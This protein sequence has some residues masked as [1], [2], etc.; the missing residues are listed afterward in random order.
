MPLGSLPARHNVAGAKN[1]RLPAAVLGVGWRGG[2]WSRHHGGSG[3][4]R[5][6]G[7]S[8]YVAVAAVLV[9]GLL[10]VTVAMVV[11][12]LLAP[13]AP[14]VGKLTTYESGVDPVGEGWAQT[15][16]RYFVYAFLY[17]VFAV[18]AVYLFPWAHVLRSSDIGTASLVEMGIFIGVI[19][20]GLAH[21]A[22]RGLLRWV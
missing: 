4:A 5:L 20:L 19:V 6:A 15:K 1:R 11:R 8:G 9:A 10:L 7:M 13:H 21:A 16:V 14:H 18:D 22:R 2:A 3:I 12:R 17:V